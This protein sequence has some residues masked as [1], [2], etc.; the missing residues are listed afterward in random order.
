[1][2]CNSGN[3]IYKIGNRFEIRAFK[4][5]RNKISQRM[6]SLGLLPGKVFEIV[7]TAPSGDPVQIKAKGYNISLRRSELAL[8]ELFSLSSSVVD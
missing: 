4:E 3:D 7:C 2:F 8:L 1:M 5:P 6:S